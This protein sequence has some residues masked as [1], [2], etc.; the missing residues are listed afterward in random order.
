MLTL[1]N[2][3]KRYKVAGGDLLALKGIN[4]SFRKNEFVSILGPSGCGKTTTLN[5]VGG[6]DKYTSGDLI[7]NGKSTKNFTDRD[8]DVYRNH[9]IGFIFQSYNLIP[10]QTVLGNV[11]LAL[12]I[13]GVS[14]EERIKR[15]KKALEKVGLSS[16][17]NKYPNQLSGGQCQRVAIARALV[18]E[19][20]I[21]LADEPTGA[22]DSKT[23]VQIMDLIK[24]ISKEKLVIMVTHNGELAEKY[25]TRIVKLFDG[26]I[27][28]DTNPYIVEDK[29]EK[30]EVEKIDKKT[31]KDKAKMSWW[32]AFKLSAR[33]LFTKRGRTALTSIAGSI[34][35]I[36]IS[37]VLAVSTG[38]RTYIASMQDDMLSGNPIMVQESAI[39]FTAMSEDLSFE[40]KVDFV[41]QEGYVNVDKMI[42]FL[43]KQYKA[44]NTLFTQNDIRQEYVDYVKAM[45]KEYGTLNIDY[46]IDVTNNIYTNFNKDA[47][48]ERNVSLSAIKQIY[49][50]VI[51]KTTLSDQAPVIASLGDV[52]MVKPDDN[53][54]ILTQYDLLDGQLAKEKDEIMIV[55]SKDT[56]LTDLMLGQLGYYTQDEFMNIVSKVDDVEGNENPN[57]DKERFS[58]QELK[59]KEFIWYDNA[60]VFGKKV[61]V[62]ANFSPTGTTLHSFTYN[63]NS[64][65][66]TQEQKD[67][68][69]KLK[70]VGILQPKENI[71]FGCLQSGI[72]YTSALSEYVIEK[73]YDS[74]IATHFRDTTNNPDG[75]TSIAAYTYDFNYEGVDYSGTAQVGKY[76]Q[77]MS[78][79]SGGTPVYQL[80]SR[81]LGGEKVAN[82]IY[83]YPSDFDTKD[84]V[85]QY[86]D[87]WNSEEDIVVNGKTYTIEDRIETKYTD[88]LSLV[89]SMINTMIDV[90]T[91]ALIAFT[92]LSLVVSCVMIAI[93]T[94]V[95]V[96]ERVK[97]IGVIRSLGGRK[98]DVSNL[99]NVE[100]LIIGGMSGLFGV[101]FTYLLSLIVNVIIQSLAGFNI[102][103]LPI[104]TALILITLS[105]LLTVISGLIPA[106]KAAQQDPV[107]ALRT[108]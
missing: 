76:N 4:V 83:I 16:E 50:G 27:V 23:S 62:P 58:Y 18:N 2:I 82:S 105:I 60:T 86:L 79:F 52:F 38:V 34:G 55:L 48:S 68:G 12:T 20:D 104:T 98:R 41:K 29:Q 10:H 97:E 80:T 31:K 26:E 88:T 15:S 57:L 14:K 42:E 70:V 92:S 6:L 22:L 24:E 67:N 69:L 25:S 85:N 61:T 59:G 7:I 73:N 94:Y 47:E 21:L 65:A 51:G 64:S 91:Y 40:E 11:E 39:D 37:A 46:G 53:D 89:I 13:S 72:Y 44:V 43:A 77:M 35:I 3:T 108:E 54:Y 49:T 30:E 81:H 87:K 8:W 63:Y 106:R 1:K 9:R 66:F 102:M 71:N 107:V 74:E 90:V 28:E 93:I 5:I 32:T 36:G 45:P 95:S 99:F 75:S 78:M 33:N 19:P 17:I 56:A 101:G 96:M 84:L 103:I 100:T